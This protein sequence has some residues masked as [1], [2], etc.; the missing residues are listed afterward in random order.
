MLGQAIVNSGRS[1][2][3]DFVR[4]IISSQFRLK[5]ICVSRGYNTLNVGSAANAYQPFTNNSNMTCEFIANT[6]TYASICILSS[7]LGVSQCI[8]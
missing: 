7:I 6:K 8:K 2:G 5:W 1:L 4:V 3:V